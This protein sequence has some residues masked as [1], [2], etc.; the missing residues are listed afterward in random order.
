MSDVF[1]LNKLLLSSRSGLVA[2]CCL[3]RDSLMEFQSPLSCLWV[4]WC[5]VFFVFFFCA[6]NATVEYLQ[7]IG[8]TFWLCVC[9]WFRVLV[10]VH[11][12]VRIN[13]CIVWTHVYVCLCVLV[14]VCVCL[15]TFCVSVWV[16]LVLHTC[17]FMYMCICLHT[18]ICLCVCVC[19]HMVWL[20]LGL[21]TCVCVC[22]CV[23]GGG[24]GLWH[25]AL[26]VAVEHAALQGE[27]FT[28]D[29][30]SHGSGG[31]YSPHMHSAIHFIQIY[32]IYIE[33]N[34]TPP[35]HTHT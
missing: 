8:N 24:P 9:V 2:C 7:H 10:S 27:T 35:P 16:C 23:C 14:C 1:R 4:V 34:V 26:S 12:G 30:K 18:C 33:K 13:V 20:C 31:S 25:P 22:V 29:Q 3:F 21:H 5:L 6:V 11:M 19:T 32:T 17:Q 15:H 28:L